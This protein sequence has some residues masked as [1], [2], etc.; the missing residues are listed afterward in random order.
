MD[1][2][3]LYGKTREELIALNRDTSALGKDGSYEQTGATV[4]GFPAPGIYTITATYS[5]VRP[6]SADG[7]AP[8]ELPKDWWIGDLQTNPITIQIGDPGK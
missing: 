3:T 1:L 7:K 6:R 8:A 2:N 5:V 4:Y